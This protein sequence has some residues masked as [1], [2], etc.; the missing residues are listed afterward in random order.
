MLEPKP[1]RWIL[2]GVLFWALLLICLNAW[3]N[4]PSSRKEARHTCLCP[5]SVSMSGP[6]DLSIERN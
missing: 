1:S 3:G 6:R 2:V 5:D 4:L